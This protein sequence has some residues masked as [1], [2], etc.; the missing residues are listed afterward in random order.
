MAKHA[1]AGDISYALC[2]ECFTKLPSEAMKEHVA[3][4]A[5]Y[6]RADARRIAESAARER[7]SEKGVR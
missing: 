1:R 2:G 7:L 4:C 3:A 6:A 5:A